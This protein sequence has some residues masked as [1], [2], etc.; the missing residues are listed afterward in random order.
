[1]AQ[2]WRRGGVGGNENHR[3]VHGGENISA[4]A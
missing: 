1:M 2:A 3:S 4:A